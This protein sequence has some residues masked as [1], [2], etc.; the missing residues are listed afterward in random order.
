MNTK[1]SITVLQKL[2]SINNNRVSQYE[3]AIKG[4]DDAALR[5]L[6]NR[7]IQSSK[8]C[9]LELIHE[10]DH[11]GGDTVNPAEGD[12]NTGFSPVRHKSILQFLEESEDRMLDTYNDVLMHDIDFLTIEQHKTIYKQYV[13]IKEEHEKARLLRESLLQYN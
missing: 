2:I 13:L 12:S 9:K 6:F 5:E 1:K 4:T 11:L 3:S 7:F 8:R 10:I